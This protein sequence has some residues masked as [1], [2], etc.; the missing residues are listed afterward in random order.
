MKYFKTAPE[1]SP[2]NGAPFEAVIL[3]E[4]KPIKRHINK[5]YCQNPMSRLVPLLGWTHMFSL[6]VVLR[7]NLPMGP[8]RLRND[9]AP[10]QAL[11]GLSVTRWH[12]AH[13]SR[14][15]PSECTAGQWMFKLGHCAEQNWRKL[16]GFDYLAKVITG[17]TF[18]DGI[19]A[20]KPDQIAA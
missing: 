15:I 18:K 8:I 2:Q 9:P 10:H 19:E 1:F 16:R 7:T 12:A 13:P 20:T 11:T 3:G 4:P 17:V 6:S 14:D 5:A